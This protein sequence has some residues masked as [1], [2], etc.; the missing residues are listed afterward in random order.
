[1]CKGDRKEEFLDWFLGGSG[2][3]AQYCGGLV[4]ACRKS[5]QSHRGKAKR[6]TPTQSS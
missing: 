3:P 2:L 5:S 4:S 1:V 6:K